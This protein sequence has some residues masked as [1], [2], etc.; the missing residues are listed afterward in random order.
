MRDKNELSKAISHALRHKPEEYGINLDKDG[1]I[2]LG[3][4]IEAL[5]A[6]SSTFSDLNEN[7]VYSMIEQSVKKRH[8]VKEQRIRAIYGHSADVEI[9]YPEQNPPL[10]LYHGT[11]KDNSKVI[12]LE[13]LKPMSRQYVHLTSSVDGAFNVGSRKDREPVILEVDAYKA[14]LAGLKFYL[15]DKNIWLSKFVSAEFIHILVKDGA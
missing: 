5:K 7:D 2:E 4:L 12:L 1:W 11:S 10:K 3:I 15:A 6:K 13:G 8:E 9:E 14:S